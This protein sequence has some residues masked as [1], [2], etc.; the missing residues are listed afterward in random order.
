M[1]YKEYFQGI[2]L[3]V[4]E[5]VLRGSGGSPLSLSL[6]GWPTLA[7]HGNIGHGRRQR[8]NKITTPTS[9]LQRPTYPGR[10]GAAKEVAY[11]MADFGHGIK[12]NTGIEAFP[13]Q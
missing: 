4:K 12:V 3:W 13:F 10:V 5:W 1:N 9:G 2:S 6:T 8:D 7:S 11:F